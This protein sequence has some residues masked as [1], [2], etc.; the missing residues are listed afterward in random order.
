MILT[1][2]LGKKVKYR[3]LRLRDFLYILKLFW[4][5]CSVELKGRIQRLQRN[6]A[7]RIITGDIYYSTINGNVVEIRVGSPSERGNQQLY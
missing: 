5:N 7:G 4:N 6:K 2:P 3:I 1:E